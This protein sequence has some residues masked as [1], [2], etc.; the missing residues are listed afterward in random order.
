M[1][2]RNFV[3]TT[4]ALSA[5]IVG[6][7]PFNLTNLNKFFENNDEL[8]IYPFL[9]RSVNGVF[10]I[11]DIKLWGCNWDCKWCTNKFQPLNKAMPITV[12]INEIIDSSNLMHLDVP[13]PTL[14]VISGGEPLLQKV[15]V[16]KLIASLKRKTDYTISLET[17]GYLIDE[18]FIEKVNKL[19]LDRIDISFRNIDDEWHKWYTGGYS[20][21]HVIDALK[22]ATET[23]E[24]LIG[25][26]IILFSAI[27]EIIFEKMCKL[28]HEI[29]PDFIIKMMYP[30][31][32][33]NDKHQLERYLRN[34]NRMGKIA[35]RYFYRI[36]PDPDNLNAFL[37]REMV[38]YE[39]RRTYGGVDITKS[40][41]WKRGEN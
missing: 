35:S 41:R 18:N 9:Y 29:N 37:P 17:N 28:L 14:F 13:L 6:I 7:P 24:G 1:S 20:N 4:A 3:K 39:V 26:P 27:N 34:V 16:L 30:I 21:R 15:E 8:I 2:R 5:A 25:V 22:L 23:F 19:N 31:R 11:L 10:Q 12:S 38:Q 33:P 40:W 36:F 32:E